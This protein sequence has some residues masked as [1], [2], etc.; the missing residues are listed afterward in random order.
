MPSTPYQIIRDLFHEPDVAPEH[1]R[2]GTCPQCL[3]LTEKLR[4]AFEQERQPEDATRE[5]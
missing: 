4:E 5:D 3:W 2:G 1:Y